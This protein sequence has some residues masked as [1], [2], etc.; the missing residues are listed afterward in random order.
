[1]RKSDVEDGIRRLT[2]RQKIEIACCKINLLIGWFV[3]ILQPK[4]DS[5]KKGGK[6]SILKMKENLFFTFCDKKYLREK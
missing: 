3:L 6:V 2:V 4:A 5:V 1:M